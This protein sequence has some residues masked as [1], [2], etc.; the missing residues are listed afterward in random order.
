MRNL[1]PVLPLPVLI[2]IAGI[3][4]LIMLIVWIA[5]GLVFYI[6]ERSNFVNE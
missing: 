6:K 1:N 4:A 5:I 2:T 3:A